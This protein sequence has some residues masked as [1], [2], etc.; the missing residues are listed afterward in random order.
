[1]LVFVEAEAVGNAE[2]TEQTTG[3]VMKKRWQDLCRMERQD[4][5]SSSIRQRPGQ[6]RQGS[7]AVLYVLP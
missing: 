1:M 7:E 4:G 3:R 5:P 6:G 2:T